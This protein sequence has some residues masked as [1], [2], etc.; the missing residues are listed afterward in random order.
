MFEVAHNT[1]LEKLILIHQQLALLLKRLS[2]I[3]DTGIICC[4]PVQ[5][6]YQRIQNQCC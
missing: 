2:L 3:L 5:F 4:V 6:Y 1:A